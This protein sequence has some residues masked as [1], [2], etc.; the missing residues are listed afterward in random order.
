MS[1][2]HPKP[3]QR[4]TARERAA[5][6]WCLPQ[7][8]KREMDVEFGEA[9]ANAIEAAVAAA[10]ADQRDKG[11][12]GRHPNACWV[13][14]INEAEDLAKLPYCEACDDE[15][16]AVAAAREEERA[17][18]AKAIISLSLPTGH[19][20]T[21]TDIVRT[22]IE[23]A[24]ADERAL[25][26]CGHARANLGSEITFSDEHCE[27]ICHACAREQRAVEEAVTKERERV[28]K[29][30]KIIEDDAVAEA[31][32]RVRRECAIDTRHIIGRL[33]I[34]DD[35]ESFYGYTQA[36]IDADAIERHE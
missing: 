13:T 19:G 22:A 10:R 8:S 7:F 16:E 28:N 24:R 6:I 32:A 35:K 5:Q 3:E 2:Q 17:L 15:V 14:Y 29:L 18:V 1:E 31:E 21:T 20:D 9:I 30:S 36:M 11:P 34:G 23:Q 25:M 4:P 12:C 33:C 27:P 26:G